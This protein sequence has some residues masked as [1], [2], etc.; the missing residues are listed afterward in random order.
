MFCKL[1]ELNATL[2][3]GH[4]RDAYCSATIWNRKAN[5]FPNINASQK[6]RGEHMNSSMHDGWHT[7]LVANSVHGGYQR[8]NR[9]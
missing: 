3:I 9:V 2:E 5:L 8:F 6:C 1:E 4:L 7:I